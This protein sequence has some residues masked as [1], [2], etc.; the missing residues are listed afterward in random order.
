[1]TLVR[2]QDGRFRFRLGSRD[3]ELLSETLRQYPATPV[4]H[5][6]LSRSSNP[7]A[8]AGGQAMLEE[9]MRSEKQ[10]HKQRIDRFLKSIAPEP[11][12]SAAPRVLTLS[13]DDLEWLLQVL[14]DVRVGSWIRLGCPDT[15]PGKRPKLAKTQVPVLATLEIAGHFECVILHALDAPPPP[16]P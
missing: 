1:M 11:S 3:F 8:E 6:R 13:R 4:D 14:N 10:Q 15:E 16:A 12:T 9:F 2:T 7:A 5:H